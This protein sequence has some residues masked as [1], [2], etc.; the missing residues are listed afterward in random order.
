MVAEEVINN[1]PLIEQITVLTRTLQALGGVIFLYILFGIINVMF[2][3]R[4]KKEM[5]KI[6]NRLKII[7]KILKKNK[8]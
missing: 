1:I 3:R 7:E 5:E 6:N 4:K 8:K 2:N